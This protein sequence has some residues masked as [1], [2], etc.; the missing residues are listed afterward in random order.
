MAQLKGKIKIK[1]TLNLKSGLHIGDS[2]EKVEIGGIDSP[3]IRRKDNNQPY[4][5]GSS[6][7]GKIRSLLE[8]KVGV[9]DIGES[10]EINLIF[11][12]ASNDNNIATCPSRLIFR[13]AYLTY[14]S[15]EL[16]ERSDYLDLPY[17]EAKTETAINRVSGIADRGLRTQE[18]V[19]AGV[20]F[21]IEIIVNELDDDPRA[22]K[23]LKMLKD[24]IKLLN[25]DYLGGGG[26]RG[27]GHIEIALSGD[28]YQELRFNLDQL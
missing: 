18:R 26:S 15:A 8:Q 19:P 6:L 12:F 14:K 1:T 3:V 11:G 22:E 23:A 16:L 13:D 5:P 25:L 24:G 2:K 20:S 9:A 17:T 28:S 4:I 27:S 21:D 7:K 10:K